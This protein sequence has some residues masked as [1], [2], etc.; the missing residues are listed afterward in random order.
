MYIETERLIL[1]NFTDTDIS[2]ATRYL[3][4]NDVM[5]YVEKPFSKEQ[6]TKF[7]KSFGLCE[8]PLIYALVERQT[9]LLIG[10]IIFHA[11]DT[12]SIYELGW[13]IDKPY[14]GKGYCM[15]IS[16][17]IIDYAFYDIKIEKLIAETVA[18][19]SKSLLLIKRLGMVETDTSDGLKIFSLTN[20]NL[21]N[22]YNLQNK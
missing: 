9:N 12:T 16:K 15:E 3:G 4:D 5:Q 7:I 6:V 17:V 19:N 22:E 18:E 2:N 13:I 1:R 20:S 14:W 21:I 11:F 8:P 10:H